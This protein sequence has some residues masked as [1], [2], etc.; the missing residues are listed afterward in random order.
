MLAAVILLGISPAWS[1]NSPTITPPPESNRGVAPAAADKA[2]GMALLSAHVDNEGVLRGGADPEFSVTF[3]RARPPEILLRIYTIV[4]EHFCNVYDDIAAPCLVTVPMADV[5]MQPVEWLWPGRIASGK[6]TVLAG[7]GVLGKS[8]ILF[9]MAA[10]LSRGDRWP[11]SAE[12]AQVRSSV[13]LSSEDDAADT[14]KPRLAAAG[15]DMAKVHVVEMVRNPAGDQKQFSLQSELDA[16]ERRIRTIGDVG[17]LI[18]DPVTAYLGN[19]DSHRNAAVRAVLG[20]LA[21]MSARVRIATICNT[22]FS[23]SDSRKANHRFIGSVAFVNQART[24]IIVTQDPDDKERRLFIPSKSNIGKLG[25]GL[26]FRIEPCAVPDPAR[27]DGAIVATRIAWESE[28]VT[29][30]A[31]AAVA[32]HGGED[33]TG[34]ARAIDFLQRELAGGAMPAGEILK[35]ARDAGHAVKAVRS[36]RAALGIRPSK[37]AHVVNGPWM[38]ELPETK[39]G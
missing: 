11:A 17:L 37:A 1:Q 16:L 19:V 2:L 13:I 27:E 10:R 38:W 5:A 4:A 15:A 25:D 24:A 20:P 35:L 36:A 6:V 26:A 8:T 21:T 12:R 9:D 23:K 14:I 31:D 18:I 39:R 7:D 28:P 29:I 22:H 3:H 32:F 34:K 33:T 30:S